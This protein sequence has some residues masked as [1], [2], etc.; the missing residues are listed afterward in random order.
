[1][2]DYRSLYVIYNARLD[3]V[4]VGIVVDV[5]SY[6]VELE[7]A[8]GCDLEVK[9]AGSPC[10]EARGLM[11][12]VHVKFSFIRVRGEWFSGHV[13]EICDYAK[14]V[15]EG[16]TLPSRVS[17]Y[18]DGVSI[19]EISRQ[20]GVSR[21]A[22]ISMLK[23]YGVYDPNRR[24]VLGERVQREIKQVAKSLPI[25]EAPFVLRE[26]DLSKFGGG[27]DRIAKNLYASNRGYKVMGMFPGEGM[28]E[29]KFSSYEE[30]EVFHGSFGG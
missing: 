22:V 21:Q 3:L 27:Y 13:G 26:V 28:K 6:K 14:K 7:D 18:I 4:R 16:V 1:M 29:I 9:F 24:R 23:R 30:L 8:C 20:D 25:T 10:L 15:S 19:S 2:G 5:L 11:E 17:R 12:D